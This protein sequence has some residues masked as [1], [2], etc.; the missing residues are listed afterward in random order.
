MALI[1]QRA[2][3]ARRQFPEIEFRLFAAE[4]DQRSLG[5]M[6]RRKRRTS[7]RMPG[8]PHFEQLLGY[9]SW[10]LTEHRRSCR[11][12]QVF[13]CAARVWIASFD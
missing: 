4:L 3:V 7:P 11:Q 10:S 12:S 6:R 8:M 5:L 1:E 13:C 2:G 9:Q